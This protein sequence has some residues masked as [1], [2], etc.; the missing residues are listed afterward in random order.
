[1]VRA[2]R[3]DRL[4]IVIAVV[5]CISL[6]SADPVN[7]PVLNGSAVPENSLAPDNSTVLLNSTG[8][9][10]ATVESPP[11]PT[12][13]RLF[14]PSSGSIH[15]TQVHGAINGKNGSVLF[16]T[17]YGL[18]AYD[19]DW[20]TRH[21]TRDDIRYGLLSDF[22]TAIGYD[23]SGNLWIGYGEG[24]QID[25]GTGWYEIVRDQQLLK[26]L[27]IK[28]FQRWGDAMWVATGNAGI[29]RYENGSWTW[30]KP[31]SKDGPG[32]YEIDSMVLDPKT[33]S[34]LIATDDAG[35]W[36]IPSGADP[37]RFERLDTNTA[38]PA[39]LLHIRQD[40][41]GGAYLFDKNSVTKYSP[42]SGFDPVLTV[43]GLTEAPVAIND[44]A[45]AHDGTL[46]VATDDGI[47]VWR[48]GAV[49]YHL[50]RFEGIGTSAIVTWV[51]LDAEN[52]L[53]FATQKDVG[54]Y[55]GEYTHL[56]VIPVRIL[57]PTSGETTGVET[58]SVSSPV[59]SSQ[60]QAPVD[61]TVGAPAKDPTIL[62]RI[63]AFF[64][65]LIPGSPL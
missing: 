47:Y 54:Y 46:F 21:V 16:A 63:I 52:R 26:S 33:G 2:R 29:H 38:G 40:P 45:A 20:S 35:I 11:V 1:M 59:M 25:N 18:S 19:G 4:L 23:S 6:V 49:L 58:L 3:Y 34:L 56:P 32:F 48:D 27:R 14:M 57:T 55:S 51:F 65:G 64:S 39:P 60:S 24:I 17:S 8:P 31:K 22:I 30:F 10:P 62:E 42:D 37:V 53:W 9:E 28:A 15:S 12:D 41:L 13:I 44:I 7:S 43:S 36:R 50:S 5:F 61:M